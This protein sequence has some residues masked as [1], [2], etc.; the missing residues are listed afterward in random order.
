MREALGLAQKAK[1]LTSPNPCVGAILVRNGKKIGEGFHHKAG[2]PH[3]EVLAVRN[4]RESKYGSQINGSTLYVTLEPCCTYGKTPPCT[5]MIIRE[6][7]KRVVIG[8][9]DPNP[10]HA[11]KGPRILR[12][13]GI[14]VKTGVLRNECSFL[15]RDFNYW[16]THRRPWVTLKMA[17]SYDGRITR[18]PGEGS[19]LTSNESQKKAHELRLESDAILIGRRP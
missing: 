17:M 11:G 19:W 9:L 14:D 16:I 3:A 15:N 2:S 18:P 13:A 5:E 12:K 1:G 4:A 8:T 10:A 7:I 6:K